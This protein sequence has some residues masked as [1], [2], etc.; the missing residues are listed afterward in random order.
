M[1]LQNKNAVVLGVA[2]ES[3]IAWAIAQRL[4]ENGANVYIG[5]QQKFFSRVRLLLQQYPQVQGQRCD[6]LNDEELAAF[7]AQ[8]ADKPV[9]ILVHGIAY[10]PPDVF[11]SPPSSVTA[12]DFETTLT[13]STHSLLKVSGAAKP[14]LRDWASIM[15]LTYQAS[16]H[17]SPFYGMMGVAKAAL[18]SCVRY[19]AI[20]MGQQRARVNAISPGP[21]ETPAALGE[22]LAFL[23]DPEALET[24]AG[25]VL[26]SAVAAMKNDPEMMNEPD[27][28]KAKALWNVVQTRVAGECALPEFITQDDVADCALFLSSDL[29]RKITGQVIRIDG[30]MST[31]RLMPA[32]EGAPASVPAAAQPAAPEASPSALAEQYAEGVARWLSQKFQGAH[33]STVTD[34]TASYCLIDGEGF[35]A[36]LGIDASLHA[37]GAD[38]AHEHF[39]RWSLADVLREANGTLVVATRDGLRF[40]VPDATSPM[41]GWTAQ[42]LASPEIDWRNAWSFRFSDDSRAA[43]FCER[44]QGLDSGGA[45]SAQAA[46]DTASVTASRHVMLDVVRLARD[47]FS[48]QV[49]PPGVASLR[50]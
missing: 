31:S 6:V 17:A 26:R 24:P 34:D 9:D 41:N 21:I 40:A 47:E 3:S 8:F 11:T 5:F 28:V 48:G 29:S 44:L 7:F 33:V 35:R 45:I 15:T 14:Y 12:P 13:I 22:M 10:G 39:E 19:L 37:L 20:E 50:W 2:D 23:R 43:A 36:S 4:M 46:G 42:T 32:S 16:E 49:P 27:N 30:G 1:Q 18:E 38:A 25:A